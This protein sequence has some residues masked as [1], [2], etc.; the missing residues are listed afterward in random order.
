MNEEIKLIVLGILLVLSAIW[1]DD[2]AAQRWCD[3]YQFCGE[4]NHDHE[5]R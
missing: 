1:M 5:D 2:G 3:T 4:H